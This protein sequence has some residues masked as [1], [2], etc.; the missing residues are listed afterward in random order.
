MNELIEVIEEALL[1]SIPVQQTVMGFSRLYE[2]NFYQ[3]AD[4]PFQIID[5]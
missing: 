4:S 2:Y 3:K 5:A 1:N